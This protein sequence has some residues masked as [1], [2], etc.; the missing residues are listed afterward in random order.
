MFEA[1]KKII[2]AAEELGP[3]HDMTV[4]DWSGTNGKMVIIEGETTDGLDYSME[5]HLKRPD[6]EEE[7]DEK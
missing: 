4:I 6:R 3:A 5:V 1:L 2:A 7:A